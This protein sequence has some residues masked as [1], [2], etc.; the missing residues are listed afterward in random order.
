MMISLY[1]PN[2]LIYRWPEGEMSSLKRMSTFVGIHIRKLEEDLP[3]PSSLEDDTDSTS[4]IEDDS[5]DSDTD[6]IPSGSAQNPIYIQDDDAD[7]GH[8]THERVL[9]LLAEG[10]LNLNVTPNMK[11]NLKLAVEIVKHKGNKSQESSDK[12]NHDMIEFEA[13]EAKC[14]Y[15]ITYTFI[16]SIHTYIPFYSM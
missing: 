7:A 11:R 2:L 12:F 6:S 3:L 1:K 16:F 10:K 8:K 15:L 4:S 9:K 5:C 13:E 14:K